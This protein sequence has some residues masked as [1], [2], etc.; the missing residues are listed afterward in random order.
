MTALALFFALV[1]AAFFGPQP[2]DTVGGG[3][4][5]AVVVQPDD[6]VGGG[7]ARTPTTMDTVGG[8]PARTV[9]T[10]DTVGGGPA[11]VQK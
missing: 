9:T 3:P 4:A 7:P 10:M 11:M 8:G 1:Q 6:T 5:A 2:M